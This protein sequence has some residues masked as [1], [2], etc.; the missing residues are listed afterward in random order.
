MLLVTFSSQESWSFSQAN[1][2]WLILSERNMTIMTQSSPRLDSSMQ[3]FQLVAVPVRTTGLPRV[4]D[5]G[6]PT[7]TP[8]HTH[9]Y[10]HNNIHSQVVEQQVIWH[11]RSVWFDVQPHMVLPLLLLL[12]S[13]ELSPFVALKQGCHTKTIYSNY[14]D[15]YMY[16]YVH[17]AY[18]II[19]P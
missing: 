1:Q 4:K 16:W 11:L 13:R 17:T 3:T 2:R 6:G 14:K 5:P 15:A 18:Y 10:L 12:S 19:L 7:C 8:T 9:R